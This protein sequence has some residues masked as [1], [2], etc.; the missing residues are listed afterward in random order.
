MF[1]VPR[2]QHLTLLF[3]LDVYGLKCSNLQV[4]HFSLV[5]IPL[6]SPLVTEKFPTQ[7]GLL[8][9]NFSPYRCQISALKAAV[10]IW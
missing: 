6:Q 4:C 9:L 2:S 3:P 1:S 10:L 7:K 5:C 8:V